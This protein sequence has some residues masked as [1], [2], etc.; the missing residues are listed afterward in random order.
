MTET[1][2]ASSATTDPLNAFVSAVRVAPTGAGPLDGLTLAVKDLFDLAGQVT[3][4]G[5][6]EWA[7]THAPATTHAP[8]VATLLAAGAEAVGK[9]HT[10]ELA[11]SLMGANAHYGTPVN[12]AAPDRMPGG[13]SSGSAAAVAG[14]M[15]EI[16]LGTDTGGSV[17]IPASFCGLVGLRTTHGAV[18]IGGTMPLAPS[19]DAVGWLARSMDVV[20]R[21][22]EVFGMAPA[23][24]GPK[25]LLLPVDIWA[26]AEASTVDAL[27]EPLSRLEGA[28]GPATPVVLAPDGL[29]AWFA[30]FRVIQAAEA[31]AAHGAWIEAHTPA[32]GPGVADRFAMAARISPAERAEA[33]KAR[34]AVRE[35]MAQVL[36]AD[37]LLVL[38]TAPAPAPLCDAA[39]PVLDRFRSR[40]LRMLCPA[41]LAGLPQLSLPVARVDDAPI[42]LSLLGPAGR[43]R[44]LIAA[45]KAAR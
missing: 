27:A 44:T 10:D 15:A 20:D 25:R 26:E 29:A 37:H 4:G 24:G 3:G 19:F 42:G 28:H 36:T 41:G 2:N 38:P 8:A 21:V 31:W 32:F 35:R 1:G 33:E 34:E 16:G 5:N 6:P 22:A 12:S 45:A 18:P 14:G 23:E 7:R 11:Y 30:A 17:R 13:S 39:E 43:D 9:T 40:A